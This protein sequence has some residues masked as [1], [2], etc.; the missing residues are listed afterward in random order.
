MQSSIPSTAERN[1]TCTGRDQRSLRRRPDGPACAPQSRRASLQGPGEAA[2]RSVRAVGLHC[3]VQVRLLPGQSELGTP[4]HRTLVSENAW[5]TVTEV[6]GSVRGWLVGFV[7]R[8]E[9][10][11]S[12]G[13]ASEMDGFNLLSLNRWQ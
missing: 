7:R 3:E 1:C 12:K 5:N 10:R 9:V 8:G 13:L 6:L 2:A 4:G 11:G